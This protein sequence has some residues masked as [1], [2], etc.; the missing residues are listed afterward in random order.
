MAEE[1]L[2]KVLAHAGIASR[3]ASERLIS[4]G[5]VMV[6]GK[7]VTELGTK[8]DPSRDVIVVDGKLVP[9]GAG[10][11]YVLL[12]KPVG[13][14]SSVE[15]RWGRRTVLD[16]VDLPGRVYPVGRLDL[17]SEG[18]ILLT[19]DGEITNFLTHPRYEQ[20]KTYIVLVRGEPSD[21]DLQKMRAGVPLPDG[22]AKALDVKR[23]P[24][25]PRSA[26]GMA[27]NRPEGTTWLEVTL[28]EGHK[29]EIRRMLEGL[30]YSVERL[31]RVGMGPL[32]LEGL[33]PG[34]SRRLTAVELR[35][36]NEVRLEAARAARRPARRRGG[37]QGPP[38]PAGGKLPGATPRRRTKTSANGRKKGR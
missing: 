32:Q 2:Q 19:N 37:H 24:G 3:R 21:A 33:R 35:A 7:V 30:G 9:L 31:I 28:I 1:R 13:I 38:P 17:D 23:L 18:L 14:I 10:K 12:N 25:I 20:P 8:V 5:R 6:N 26:P 22:V 27:L 36:L 34:E 16:L 4:A 15:D 11:V 29:R